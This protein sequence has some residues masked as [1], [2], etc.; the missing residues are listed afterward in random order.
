M[1]S[2]KNS[3]LEGTRLKVLASAYACAPNKGS[4]LGMGW[5]W[6]TSLARHCRLTVISE[7]EFRL[8]IEN[9]L[10]QI[11]PDDRPEFHFINVS[12]KT[13]L[14]C[15]NQGDWRFYNDYKKWQIKVCE[16]AGKLIS[17]NQFDL[18]HQLNMIGYRE[19][20]YLWKLSLPLVWGPVGGFV[21][22][23][24]R[25]MPIL[26][27]KDAAFYSVRNLLNFIQMR[28]SPRIKTAAARANAVVAATRN[29]QEAIRR[30]HGRKC[31]IISETGAFPIDRQISRNSY[32][33]SR[34]LRITWCGRFLGLK[35]LPLALRAVAYIKK[36]REIE[37]H[38]IGSGPKKNSWK[39]LASSLGIDSVC[40]WLGQVDHKKSVEIIRKNDVL[41][42]TSVQDATTNTVLE[43][44]GSGTPVICHDACGFGTAINDSCGIRIPMHSPAKSI[45]GFAAAIEK[46]AS[47]PEL[48]A[49]L[50]KGA[51]KRA[52]ELQWDNNAKQML[53]VYSNAIDR[54]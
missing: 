10:K 49:N 31:R 13:R 23:P 28:Y 21:Q 24:W 20:G 29:D 34:A 4:E 51:L 9:A 32:D 1:E 11:Q 22:M 8:E 38:I 54:S 47:D 2:V 41:L 44:L 52:E 36:H 27:I 17:K 6:V 19:P 40:R 12:E 53:E 42:F 5:N 14:R 33:G 46:I 7:G 3:N 26:G 45:H 43:A 48:A 15:W 25:Y 16:L 30:I 37:L 18:L 35:A 39:Q 50:S